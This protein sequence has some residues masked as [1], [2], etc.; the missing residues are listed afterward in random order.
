MAIATLIPITGTAG[1]C[2][3]VGQA[4]A[5]WYRAHRPPPP[6]PRP[7]RPTPRPQPRALSL[8]ERQAVLTVLHDERF[9]DQA[10]ASVWAT[11][12]D[13]GS[14]LCSPS[15]MYRL[16]R[17]AGETGDRRRHATHPATVKPE[18]VAAAPN[19]VWS[20]DIT[21]LAG[22]A[23]WTWYYLYTILDIYSRYVVGWMVAA[24]EAAALAERL[25]ADTITNQ[26]VEAGQLTVHA[27]RGTSMTAK[28]VA[29][30]LADLGV[31]KSHSRPHVSNDNPYSEAQFKT[32]KHHPS[33]P[34][35]FG[36]VQDAR[37]FCQTFFGWY[38][39]EHRHSGIALL[40][41]AD[42][43]FGHAEQVTSARAMVLDG[44]YAAHPERFVRMP[45][46]PPRLPE[47]VWINKPL[48][49]LE[50]PQQF[51]G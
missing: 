48:D 50:A 1:A 18:L 43:H 19:R 5:T 14:Y 22:P 30:L 25:L 31:T 15:T 37:S 44:A 24:R 46:T 16:L 42:V 3:A 47:A 12:L 51:P 7:P 36:S 35:R 17:A 39:H 27:D 26:Q 23:K 29:L 38:N 13:E 41:P 21:K 45:P 34:D 4:R 20:W 28:P 2:R 32:L 6:P 49:P 8:L 9:Y 33:F 11:L 10:P 40:T